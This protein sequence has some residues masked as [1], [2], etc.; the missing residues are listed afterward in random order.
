MSIYFSFHTDFL[1]FFPQN[2][3]K[4]K[5]GNVQENLVWFWF[6]FFFFNEVMSGF[7]EGEVIPWGMALWGSLTLRGDGQPPNGEDRSNMED[8][9][10]E[11]VRDRRNGGVEGHQMAWGQRP[12]VGL[13]RA[14]CASSRVYASHHD[15]DETS[16]SP[17]PG[18][19]CPGPGRYVP[20]HPA[21][22][23]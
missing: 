5:V 20:S 23:P 3:S 17:S 19:F 13:I 9:G 16:A 2:K 22:I 8:R 4:D 6:F 12:V 7:K 18:P 15:A 11:T 21:H 1:Q 10:K 14:T